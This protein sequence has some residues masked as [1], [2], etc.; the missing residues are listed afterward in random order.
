MP[1]HDVVVT[2][3][4]I[5]SSLTVT[6]SKAALSLGR[7]LSGGTNDQPTAHLRGGLS[8]V[9]LW[10]RALGK[11]TIAQAFASRTPPSTSDGLVASWNF[12]E[13][14]GRLAA[15]G[16]GNSNAL[17]SSSSLWS[18][19]Y[20]G[21]R[22]SLF[23]DG[24]AV[25]AVAVNPGDCGDYGPSQFR[26][27]ANL[28]G[29]GAY[30]NPFLGVI[31]E[32]RVWK[33]SR[34][35]E[36]LTDNMNRY[37]TGWDKDLAGYWCF[38]AGSGDRVTDVAGH[39]NDAVFEYVSSV[40]ARPEW[41]PSSAPISNEAPPVKNALGGLDAAYVRILGEGPAVFEYSDTQV[42]AHGNYVSVMKR[43]YAFVA[44]GQLNTWVGYKVGD[45][46]RVYIGQVQTKP[47]LMGFIEGA[48]PLPSENLTRPY[49]WDSIGSYFGYDGIG[50]IMVKEASGTKV[51]FSGSREDKGGI[52][53]SFKFGAENDKILLV[54]V[55]P[56][57]PTVLEQEGKWAWKAGLGTNI[58]WSQSDKS[59]SSLGSEITRTVEH[60]LE[61]GG[62]WEAPDKV[63]LRSGERRY[64]PGND[65]YAV[66]KSATA[67]IYGL[68]LGTTGALVGLSVVPNRDIPED[69]NLISFPIDPQYVHNGSLDG[70]VG[71]Q[72]D[73]ES[74]GQPSYYRPVEAYSLQRQVE[75]QNVQ[76]AA[77]YAQ[78]DAARKGKSKD[79][80]LDT[81][82]S[83]DP[84]YDW[85]NG[86]PR[87]DM[88][89]KYVWSA[90]GG[91]YR[92]QEGY[93]SSRRES[94]GGAYEFA[95]SFGGLGELSFELGPVGIFSELELM[96]GQGFTIEVVKDKEETSALEMDVDI[97]PEGCLSKY[98]G[99]ADKPQFSETRV[100]GKVDTYRFATF[101]LAPTV[102]NTSEFFSKVIDRLWL[103]TSSEPRAAA[104]R[105]AMA[106]SQGQSAWRVLHRVTFVSRV[107]P[108]FQPVPTE[109]AAPP[110]ADPAHLDGN[111]LC[112]EL[113]RLRLGDAASSPTAAQIAAAVRDVVLDDLKVLV[114]WWNAFLARAQQANTA[115]SAALR[116]IISNM[117][118]YMVT[119]CAAR[120][121]KLWS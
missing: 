53:F 60:S 47:S 113:V 102:K 35:H 97:A 46:Q 91:L 115:E 120:K 71:L 30:G 32:I 4:G 58:E 116:T 15:D 109:S 67:D 61:S 1:K 44:N 40:P 74:G 99:T 119:Y 114:P 108:E 42:D 87:K 103:D 98:V 75:R 88:L 70:R 86:K 19:F 94:Y 66:V 105:E 80:D 68:F 28:D 56:L 112:L 77:W 73:P 96:G 110:L 121:G 101:Y 27:G 49:Y 31:D 92:E 65:G 23:V 100:P 79:C 118:Q 84:C 50:K 36:Q 76:L 14:T 37:L 62:S 21:A 22:L 39:G 17:L 25:S 93:V 7:A 85:S 82:A 12:T 89:C 54:P 48:P 78:F 18:H 11:G 90:D 45:L 8:D 29:S 106:V 5:G 72:A 16:R 63:Y 26:I 20:D 10:N 13:Q 59:E 117:N 104:L 107:P 64:L 6:R 111:T 2:P 83:L 34:T 38:D 41:I 51:S 33:V 55:P 43:G 81:Q 3:M 52:E 69:V 9:R 24:K 95:W 57:T